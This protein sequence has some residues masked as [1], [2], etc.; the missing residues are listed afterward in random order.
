MSLEYAVVEKG[1]PKAVANRALQVRCGAEGA[2]HSLCAAAEP[3]RQELLL[4]LQRPSIVAHCCS[5]ITLLG[6]IGR[7]ALLSRACSSAATRPHATPCLLCLPCLLRRT[8]TTRT[9]PSCL[10]GW[11]S[12][13]RWASW[14]RP[15]YQLAPAMSCVHA[16]L[17]CYTCRRHWAACCAH[18]LAPSIRGPAGTRLPQ[19]GIATLSS[20][21]RYKKELLAGQLTWAP[22]HESG[23]WAGSVLM[24]SACWA[25]LVAADPPAVQQQLRRRF[26]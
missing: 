25:L 4:Q 14:L 10:S 2:A 5:S 18:T 12:T 22:M 15:P 7:P 6:A 11:R 8:G 16:M 19:E 23:G 3:V 17:Q 20:F 21:E 24:L 13:C 26:Q 1:L 9:S